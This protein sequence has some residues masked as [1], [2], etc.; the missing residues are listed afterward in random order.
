MRAQIPCVSLVV[1][2]LLG[3]G[4]SFNQHGIPKAMRENDTTPCGRRVTLKAY[5][6]HFYTQPELGVHLGVL[7]REMIF[8]VLSDLKPPG[9]A[10]SGGTAVISRGGGHDLCKYLCNSVGEVFYDKSPVHTDTQRVGIGLTISPRVISGVLGLNRKREVRMKSGQSFIFYYDNTR[11][12]TP[13][14]CSFM[15][16]EETKRNDE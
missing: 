15:Y 5:G 11:P 3:A 7:E 9:T 4:C 12:G 8:P 13:D 10:D 2:F 14:Y 6:L 1:L 16:S